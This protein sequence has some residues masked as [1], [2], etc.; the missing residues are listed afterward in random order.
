[1]LHEEAVDIVDK[2]FDNMDEVNIED[3]V[4]EDTDKEV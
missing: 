1:M 3:M 4:E 2:E